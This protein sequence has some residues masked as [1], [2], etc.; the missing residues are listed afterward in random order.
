MSRIDE[1][2]LQA[3]TEAFCD[4]AFDSCLSSVSEDGRISFKAQAVLQ[5]LHIEWHKHNFPEPTVHPQAAQFDETWAAVQ[6]FLNVFFV[7]EYMP[8]GK[9]FYMDDKK[10]PSSRTFPGRPTTWDRH[11]LGVTN[12]KG[13]VGKEVEVKAPA[14]RVKV[15][16]EVPHGMTLNQV[17][18]ALGLPRTF[19][20]PALKR[21][22]KMK[23]TTKVITI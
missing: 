17:E 15:E 5:H 7:N 18:D 19:T 12:I 16:V 1:R 4:D 9:F 23:V 6:R 3:F 22:I 21:A 14:V 20:E 8:A 10:N 2:A 11:R 13:F